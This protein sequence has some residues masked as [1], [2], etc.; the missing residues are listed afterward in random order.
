[1]EENVN[2]ELSDLNAEGYLSGEIPFSDVGS[3]I[4]L[5]YQLLWEEITRENI[6]N[7]QESYRIQERIRALNDLG[8]TVGDV[9][10][11]QTADGNQLRLRA[12]VSDRNFHHDQLFN[13]T[14]IDA[15]EKQAQKMMNEIQELKATL[16]Q[17][18]NRSTSLSAAAFF[19]QQ[20]IYEPTIQKLMPSVKPDIG[21]AELYC[22]VLEH[23]WY[24]SEK[25]QRDVGHEYATEDYLKNI[26]S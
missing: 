24:L 5:R 15:E 1:M 6:I 21:E 14:G 8:F 10:L 22:Q 16:A 12:M 25:A 13:L 23:K 7:P 9:E 4:R 11:F 19:W 3:Y 2:G 17:Q 26:T 18:T 20:K